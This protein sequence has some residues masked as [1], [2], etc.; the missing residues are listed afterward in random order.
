MIFINIPPHRS[1]YPRHLS[2]DIL[3]LRHQL[4]LRNYLLAGKQINRCLADNDFRE[5]G[6]SKG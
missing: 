2:P 5:E 3:Y 6:F 4:F 1:T